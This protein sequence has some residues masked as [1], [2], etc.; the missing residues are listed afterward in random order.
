MTKSLS[1]RGAASVLICA[2]VVIG[3]AS[4]ANAETRFVGVPKNYVYDPDRGALHDYC[5]RAPDEFPAP[6]AANANFRGPCA[7]HDLCYSSRTSKF[8]CDNRL[9]DDMRTN[10]AYQYAWYNP[11][12]RACY[13]TANVYWAAVVAAN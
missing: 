9:R 12:R 3:T 5:T 13:R 8:T 2:A 10:C 6:G 4:A 11:L 1:R 7:R